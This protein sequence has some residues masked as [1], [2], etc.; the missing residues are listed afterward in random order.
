MRQGRLAVL[1]GVIALIIVSPAAARPAH[2]LTFTGDQAYV[3]AVQIVQH[4]NHAPLAFADGLRAAVLAEASLYGSAGQPI[5]LTI[6]L[7]K[8]HL[9][10]PVK[11]MVMGDNNV[12][13]GHLAVADQASGQSLGTFAIRVDA[14]RHRGASIALFVIGVVDPTGY[15]DIATQ[16]GGA[17]AATANRSGEEIAMSANFAEEALRQTFGDARAKAAHAAKSATPPPAADPNA[18]AH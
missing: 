15:V 12:A 5:V 6:D 3:A 16:V 4:D 11:A 7:D 9:K 2:G 14:E 10:N 1:G 18:P 17:A 8:V 13:A